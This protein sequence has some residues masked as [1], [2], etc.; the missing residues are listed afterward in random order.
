MFFRCMVSARLVCAQTIY[1]VCEK[2]MVL[3]MKVKTGRFFLRL[4][5][6]NQMQ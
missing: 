5:M 6:R 2:G 3:C 1:L 4:E